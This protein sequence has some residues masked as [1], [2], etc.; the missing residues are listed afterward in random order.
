M[1]SVV[2]QLGSP[3]VLVMKRSI[4]LVAGALI[5]EETNELIINIRIQ[6]CRHFNMIMNTIR[7]LRFT[8]PAKYRRAHIFK[9]LI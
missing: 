8:S 2:P 5:A 3:Q 9:V 6:M 7:D 4:Q 1:N